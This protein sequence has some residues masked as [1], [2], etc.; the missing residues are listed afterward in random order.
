MN[1]GRPGFSL[2]EM[3]FVIVIIM[4]VA[5]VAVPTFMG[6]THTDRLVQA[7]GEVQQVFEKARAR[8][9]LK[10]TA[11]RIRIDRNPTDAT[12]N[13]RIDESPDGTCSG[14]QRI[15]ARMMPP[16]DVAEA[17]PYAACGTW[18]ATEQHRCGLAE[19]HIS[20]TLAA[21]GYRQTGVTILNLDEGAPGGAWTAHES[22][23]VCVNRRGRMLRWSGAGWIPVN[24]G[25]RFRLDRREGP[26]GSFLGLLK[27][28]YVPQ[29]GVPGVLR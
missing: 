12:A 4:V 14:F 22:L 18:L 9:L 13:L 28:V 15:A 3:M 7:T 16:P 6:T 19:V 25:L 17:D 27:E 21:G 1:D 10:N 26:S 29:G 5:T 11:V 8:A 2:V 24:G 20:G 23:V